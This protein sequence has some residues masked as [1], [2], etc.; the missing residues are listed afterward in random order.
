[1]V[2]KHTQGKWEASDVTVFI[3]DYRRTIA[4]VY[5]PDN[6]HEINEIAKANAELI[7]SA[8]NLLAENT[9]LKEAH[10]AFLKQNNT[11][12]FDLKC[13][14]T[15]LEQVNQKLLEALKEL[16]FEVGLDA[17]KEAFLSYDV[18]VKAREAIA[19]ATVET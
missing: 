4:H 8:P 19:F 6:S 13:Q 15:E 1:M 11:V 12:I 17:D 18:L 16:F 2:E 14:L 9:R 10:E 3:G 7:A 5:D